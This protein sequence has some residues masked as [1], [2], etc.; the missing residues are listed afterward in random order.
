MCLPGASLNFR[1]N[2]A[3]AVELNPA[4]S[5]ELPGAGAWDVGAFGVGAAKQSD[6]SWLIVPGFSEVGQEGQGAQAPSAHAALIRFEVDAE[7]LCEVQPAS[8]SSTLSLP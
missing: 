1:V 6:G 3:G 4:R 8:E 2:A 5:L 7:A